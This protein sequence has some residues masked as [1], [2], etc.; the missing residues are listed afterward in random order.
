MILEKLNGMTILYAEGD[1][2]ITNKSRSL[3]VNV[4]YLGKGDSEN[5]YEEVLNSTEILT[6]A[7]YYIIGEEDEKGF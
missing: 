4:I 5:N 3:F 6:K 2:K 7:L 1:N